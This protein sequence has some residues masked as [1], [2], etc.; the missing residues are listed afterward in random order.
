VSDES[1]LPPPPEPPS[2][3]L[4]LY[5]E[6]HPPP[7]P[8][9]DPLGPYAGWWRRAGGRVLDSLLI[10]VVSILCMLPML[11]LFEVGDEEIVP[12]YVDPATD[13]VYSVDEIEEQID[14]LPLE[15]QAD[16]AF[17]LQPNARCEELTDGAVAVALAAGAVGLVP[18]VLYTVWWYRRLGRTGQTPGRKAVGVKVVDA[19]T[20]LPVGGGRAFGREIVAG[21]SLYALGLGYLW[22]AWDKRKQTWHDKV[23]TTVV[24]R[25]GKGPDG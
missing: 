25:V 5:A 7:P 20:G 22:A 21:F 6:G 8:P 23:I 24:V 17:R 16:A 12:C 13:E 9:T 19:N 10:L 3:P 18:A 14:D 4:P 1:N 2:P 11:V 15:A